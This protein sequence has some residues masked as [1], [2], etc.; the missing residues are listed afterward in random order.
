MTTLPP[1]MRQ[2]TNKSG[3]PFVVFLCIV[4]FVM[5]KRRYEVFSLAIRSRLNNLLLTPIYIAAIPFML[6][7]GCLTYLPLQ[8]LQPLQPL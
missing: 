6:G 1:S 5:D 2:Y 3:F 4:S 8:P 7:P